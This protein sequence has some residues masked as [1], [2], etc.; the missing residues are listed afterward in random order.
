MQLS[1]FCYNKGNAQLQTS[2]LGISKISVLVE[3]SQ[4][5]QLKENVPIVFSAPFCWLTLFSWS[6]FWF[7]WT[8]I[9]WAGKSAPSENAGPR[10]PVKPWFYQC[11]LSEQMKTSNLSLTVWFSAIK[12][13]SALTPCSPLHILAVPPWLLSSELQSIS[14]KSGKSQ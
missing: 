10:K 3:P 13:S 11:M 8:G 12:G 6:G 9:I 4:P 1:S 7:W 2:H 14:T 5:T